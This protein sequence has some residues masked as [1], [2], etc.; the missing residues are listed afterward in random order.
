MFSHQEDRAAQKNDGR[1]R[2]T[3][4]PRRQSD[5][6]KLPPL[7]KAPTSNRPH[8][9]AFVVQRFSCSF[10]F[11]GNRLKETQ[12]AAELDMEDEDIIDAMLKSIGGDA[13]RTLPS[14]R[15]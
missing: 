12:T 10:M 13:R 9:R 8:S 14:R 2:G 7:C 5:Q 11:D 6:V 1:L 3:T 4:K 15:F